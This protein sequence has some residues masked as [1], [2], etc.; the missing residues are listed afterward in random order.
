MYH[1]ISP[2]SRQPGCRAG[3][4][5]QEASWS[6]AGVWRAIA[7]TV[8]GC[9]PGVFLAGALWPVALR[10]EEDWAAAFLQPP[11]AAQP[12][13][14]WWWLDGNASRE[15]IT[16]DLEEMRRQG[17][18]G[19]LLFDAGEGKGSPV[20]PKFMSPAWREL[21][22]HTLH[23]AARLQIEVGVNL[24]SGWD[25]GGTWVT[26]EHAAKKLVF[27]ET[28]VASSGTVPIE[29]PKPATVDNFYRDVAVVAYLQ[30]ARD[31]SPPRTGLL[32]WEI[33]TGSRMQPWNQPLVN[34]TEEH[35]AVANEEDCTAETVIDLTASLDDAGRLAWRTPPGEWIVIRFGY[36]LLGSKTKCVSPG[37]QGYEIDFLSARGDGHAFRRH[38]WAAR[39]RRRS[40][41][42]H[43]AQVFS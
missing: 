13:V 2:M 21:Y 35:P 29:L 34:L 14:Y 6:L 3:G 33:K 15:G 9:L 17:I 31:P 43:H 10:A 39:P 18:A 36:T 38:G 5:S 8:V 27:A 23:E 4:L 7:R 16:R 37:S 25:A 12:W 32:N 30:R 26:P 40:L 28:L 1:R 42:R 19:V 41:G 24:C 22:Q 11:Q 20:G